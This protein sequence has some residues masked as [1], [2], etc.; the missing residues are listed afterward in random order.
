MR[1]NPQN[2]LSAPSV[3]SLV[4]KILAVN[5]DLGVE[6]IIALVRK[7]TRVEASIQT[8]DESLALELAKAFD[9]KR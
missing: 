3:G 6:E 2:L 9:A 7:A 8:I 5:P 4:K 1:M